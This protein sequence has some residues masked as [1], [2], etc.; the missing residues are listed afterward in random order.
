M[1]KLEALRTLRRIVELGSLAAAARD[2]RRSK[3]SVSKQL[4]ELE[5]ELGAKL[6]QRTT[7][8]LAVTE[9]GRAFYESSVRI[10]DDL[11][12]AQ[13]AVGSLQATPRGRLRVNC[14]MSLGVLHLAPIVTRFA[15]RFTDV[16]VELS[17]NDRVVDLLEEGFDVGLRVQARLDD[18]SIIARKICDVRRAL[19]ASP[20]YL[21][22][23]GAP[24]SP[25]DLKRHR[26]LVYTLSG[27]AGRWTLMRRGR[28]Y[29]VDVTPAFSANSGI[30]VREAAL[31]G[32]GIA[33][34]PTFIVAND[35][36]S[37]RLMEVLPGY[38]PTQ[39]ALFAIYPSSRHL[40]AKVRAFVDHVA[41]QVGDPPLW[42]TGR[43]L[44]R[45]AHL[46]PSWGPT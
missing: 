30:A 34:A 42:E 12:D 38:L 39:H 2:L 23:H 3:A 4:T 45:S 16:Q 33:N 28:R 21:A 27:N 44:R 18:A 24:T 13:R 22:R 19:C 6:I 43:R 32:L 40:P 1:D 31:R 25:D 9:A 41:E 36:A 37:G 46:R 29:Q 15:E 10:L 14:P 7:R 17:M 20:E 11:A 26:A 8:R 35:L 5:G